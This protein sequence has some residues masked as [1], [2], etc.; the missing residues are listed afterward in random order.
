M[1]INY[2]ALSLGWSICSLG[3]D[4]IPYTEHDLYA[5]QDRPIGLFWQYSVLQ[6]LIMQFR[7][8]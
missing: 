7:T 2:T 3:N 5:A 4:N 1:N 8:I 6:T